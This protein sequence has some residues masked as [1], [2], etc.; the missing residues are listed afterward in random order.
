MLTCIFVLT[1]TWH[2]TY[3]TKFHVDMYFLHL[4]AH[5]Q[6][7]MKRSRSASIQQGRHHIQNGSFQDEFLPRHLMPPP[8]SIPCYDSMKVQ[9]YWEDCI[10][11]DIPFLDP[12]NCAT[13]KTY[14]EIFT[15]MHTNIKKKKISHGRGNFVFYH[16]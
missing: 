9:D 13:I 12:Y 14:E 11:Y 16:R 3:P 5:G 2:Y 7:E 6:Q 10:R 1:G 15:I 4:Q 8:P